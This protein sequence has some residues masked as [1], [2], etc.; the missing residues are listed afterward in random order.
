MTLGKVAAQNNPCKVFAGFQSGVLIWWIW[1]KMCSAIDPAMVCN[2]AWCWLGFFCVVGHG[3]TN[4]DPKWS[5]RDPADGQE[6]LPKVV[7]APSH[8]IL[9]IVFFTTA[10]HK[11]QTSLYRFGFQFSFPLLVHRK[12]PNSWMHTICSVNKLAIFAK[13]GNFCVHPFDF[14]LPVWHLFCCFAPNFCPY[15]PST[16]HWNCRPPRPSRMW[17]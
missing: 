15:F 12:Q 5:P 3:G 16:F 14:F 6:I 11:F 8:L 9:Y 10:I 1:Q 2:A 7:F 4:V 17:Q 13:I